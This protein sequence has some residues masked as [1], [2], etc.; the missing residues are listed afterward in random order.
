MQVVC[1]HHENFKS[2]FMQTYHSQYGIRDSLR[3]IADGCLFGA[4]YTGPH[5][6]PGKNLK[7]KRRII[8]KKFVKML[9]SSAVIGAMAFGMC[10]CT[11]T[12]PTQAPTA[13]PTD[14]TTA[15]TEA[16]TDAPAADG[17]IKVGIIN[18]D[19]NE[20]GYRTANDRDMKETFTEENGYEA[21]F[22]LS[23]WYI[24]LG[25]SS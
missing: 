13:A 18:N 11:Q 9:V 7:M 6:G 4:E 12:T 16:P 21:S 23:S 5:Q 22:D 3:V 25:R 1:F 14:G 19:P 10:A 24:R 2:V 17:L 15:A 20:S 8:M